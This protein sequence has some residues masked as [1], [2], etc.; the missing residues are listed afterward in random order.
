MVTKAKTGGYAGWWFLGA[1]LTLY[2]LVALIDPQ[3]AAHAWQ[4]FDRAMRQLLPMLGVI[5]VLLLLVD[6]LAGR[7]QVIRLLGEGSG[8]RG[9]LTALLGGIIAAGPIYLWY[10][11]A[12]EL[13][14]KGMR[15]GLLV[16]FLYSRAVKLP[17]LPLLIHYFGLAYTLVLTGYLILFAL[18]SG[19]LTERGCRSQALMRSSSVAG[20]EEKR[21]HTFSWK[22]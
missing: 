17:L 16:T 12:A 5:F 10:G 6:R 13:R 21:S 14:A 1:V 19:V 4:Q 11:L 3:A 2:G 22:K 8:L 15:N 7:R 18:I 9:W 20:E